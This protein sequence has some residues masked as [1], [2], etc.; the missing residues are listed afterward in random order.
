MTDTAVPTDRT[1]DRTTHP[2]DRRGSARPED[3]RG[4]WV[5]VLF[6]CTTFVGASLL[7]M[8]QPLAAKLILPSFGGSA[9]VWS[10]SSL[11]FQ[12]LLLAGYVYAHGSTQRLGAR[13]Q[14]R[15]HLLLLALPLLALPIALPAQAA[16]SA[17]D[18][19]V[20]WLLRTLVLMVGLPFAVLST[21]GPL[22]QRWYAWAGGPRSDD[23][24][25]LFSGSNL[26]SFV[27]LLAYP[28][29]VEPLLTLTQQRTWWSAGFVVFMVL[30]AACALTVRGRTAEPGAREAVAAGRPSWRQA[31]LWCLWAFLP[32]SLM[33]A[34]TAHLSTDIA[35][36][37]LLWVLPLAAYLASFVLAFART[38][39]TVS[40][41]LVLPCV[42]L[43]VTTGIV[44]GLGSTA[45]SSLV[46]LVVG[47]NVVSVGVAG[48]A[49]HAR[50]AA[51]RPDPTQL[52]FF[53]LVVSVGGALGGLLN[54]VVAPLLFD[55][56]WEYFLTVALLPVLA[57]GVP[58]V[59]LTPRRVVVG[60]ATAAAATGAVG[61]LS[62]VSGLGAVQSAVLVAAGLVAVVVGWLAMRAPALL[63]V[64][65][66]IA[67]VAVVVVQ[68]R[69]S[70]LTERTFYGSYR[71]RAVDG[72]HRLLHG[73]TI[74]GTQFLDEARRD[75]P[76][77][78]YASDGPVGDL[79]SVVEPT[80]VGVVGLGAGAIAAYGTADTHLRFFEIDPVVARIAE[81]ERWF[82]YLGDSP[83]EVDVVVGDGRLM[84]ER[85]PESSFDLLALDAFSSDSIPVHVLTREG[86]EVFLDR[87]RPDGVLAVH[88]SNRVFDLRPVL[89][90]HARDLGLRAVIGT[91][92]EGPGAETSVWVALTRSDAVADALTDLQRW[93]P[94]PTSPS[95]EWTDDYSSV[96]S[97][98][99]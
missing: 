52:T 1:T 73:T 97:V 42:V 41:T 58:A 31:G 2:S 64:G 84:M 46:P 16:P 48:F 51:T 72:Q 98:L 93:E 30:M 39:R 26:G 15:A 95:V 66:L 61:L 27:G 63:C 21:T 96:L 92:G 47:A 99:R 45:L 80:D 34:A 89:A 29:A 43:A 69:S 10:T 37:P 77:T 81:D 11:L 18:S 59:R 28:F 87:V 82:S 68:E 75:V 94:L 86:V 3:E 6:A 62:V 53:Y 8:V 91:G 22:I 25:F 90:A 71:V 32:S 9:T 65:L 7:F 76:T 60:L 19:P 78:Y 5:A 20:L 13:W 70:L 74:H 54:G 67:A 83:A 85:E 23:P 44:S 33:L 49:A 55:G 14:P 36:V 35:A 56:V 57:I 24:Y 17:G 40:A 4:V 12:V 50:L 79:M 88:I 38:T